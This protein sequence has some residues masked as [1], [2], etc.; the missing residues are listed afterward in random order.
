MPLPHTPRDV[1]LAGD[2]CVQALLPGGG[3]SE[4]RSIGTPSDC[5]RAVGPFPGSLSRAGQT[6]SARAPRR[7]A[8]PGT[9]AGLL[10]VGTQPWNSP[11]D[12]VPWEISMDR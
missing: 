5:M 7:S 12:T 1:E 10:G 11:A 3:K 9:R 4:F 8:C 2:V 6:P